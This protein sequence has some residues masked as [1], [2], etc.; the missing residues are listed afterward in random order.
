[1]ILN[2]AGNNISTIPSGSFI[3]SSKMISLKLEHNHLECCCDLLAVTFGIQEVTGVCA[4]PDIV[5]GKSIKSVKCSEVENTCKHMD[6]VTTTVAIPSSSAIP[7]SS[8]EAILLSPSSSSSS[9][10]S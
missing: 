10:S 6:V 5:N 8:S 1:M 4:K 7:M 9:S 3:E 2:L